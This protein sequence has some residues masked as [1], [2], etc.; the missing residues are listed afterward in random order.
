[1]TKPKAFILVCEHEIWLKIYPS[2]GDPMWCARCQ[3]YRAVGPAEA[4]G[5]VTVEDGWISRPTRKGYKGECIWVEN[6]GHIERDWNWFQ[7]RNKMDRHI[8]RDHTKSRFSPTLVIVTQPLPRN[9]PP[10]F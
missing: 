10:P 6:C 3:E 2:I 7:L 9:S 8:M 4:A 5:A 1:M